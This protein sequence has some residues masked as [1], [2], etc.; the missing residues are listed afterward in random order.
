[1]STQNE[2]LLF[3]VLRKSM[4]DRSMVH[5]AFKTWF[6]HKDQIPFEV[7]DVIAFLDRKLGLDADE[8]RNLR[9]AFYSVKNRGNSSLEEIPEVLT[10]AGAVDT[11][12]E[13]DLAS[14]PNK[15]ANPRDQVFLSLISEMMQLGKS[16]SSEV[17]ED[18]GDHFDDPKLMKKMK[19]SQ[20]AKTQ[21]GHWL[22]SNL[23][24]QMKC[25]DLSDDDLKKIFHEMYVA[26]C[27]SLGPVE[28]DSILNKAVSKVDNAGYGFPV[29]H[30]I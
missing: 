14:I 5:D 12:T 8:K 20:P 13:T 30:F 28:T 25:A 1:M 2:K 21:I 17:V 3:T 27:E 10:T 18:I 11:N 9:I 15:K 22:S 16:Q 7:D 6:A 29:T 23:Q 26:F 24:T 4:S 19:I